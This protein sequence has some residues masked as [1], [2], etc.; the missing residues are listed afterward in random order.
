MFSWVQPKKKKVEP[1]GK[2]TPVLAVKFITMWECNHSGFEAR[3][4][5]SRSLEQLLLLLLHCTVDLPC[6]K[7]NWRYRW[8]TGEVWTFGQGFPFILCGGKKNMPFNF[9]LA[10]C[11]FSLGIDVLTWLV[12]LTLSCIMFNFFVCLYFVNEL[13]LFEMKNIIYPSW[14]STEFQF[15]FTKKYNWT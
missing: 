10:V 9:S 4:F 12:C 7:R 13:I 3:S 8:R 2:I 1:V 14:N 15:C 5:G 6:E 11:S